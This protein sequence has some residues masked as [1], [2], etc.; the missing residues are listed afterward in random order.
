MSECASLLPPNST[1][2]E[3]AIECATARL[4]DVPVRVREVWNPDTCPAEVL[5][6]LAWAF[7][8][9]R[10]D[11]EW[12]LQQKRDIIKASVRLHKRKGTPAAVREVIDLVLGGGEILEPWEFAGEAHTFKIRT[13]GLLASASDYDRLIRLV[14]TTKPV[15]SWLVAVQVQRRSELAFNLG[16]YNHTGA[17]I[18]LRNRIDPQVGTGR[19]WTASAL[20]RAT[21]TLVKPA[22]VAITLPDL[23]LYIGGGHLIATTTTIQPRT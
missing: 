3:R 7:S 17:T 15:R 11:A 10:W 12:S 1:D 9:D 16:G 5:P 23:P 18:Q 21:T 13:T 14:D 4:G 8:V 19:A 20:H 6:W 2:A 22:G